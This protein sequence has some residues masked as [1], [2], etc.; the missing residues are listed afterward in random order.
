MKPGGFLQGRRESSEP[1]GAVALSGILKRKDFFDPDT[2][3][4][5]I[6]TGNGLKTPYTGINEHPTKLEYDKKVLERIFERPLS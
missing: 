3:V 5:C 6:I 4:V 1:A 2:D